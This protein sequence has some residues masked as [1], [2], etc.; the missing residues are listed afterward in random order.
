MLD[1]VGNRFQH[2]FR[3]DVVLKHLPQFKN[4]VQLLDTAM[5]ALAAIPVFQIAQV[6]AVTQR[7]FCCQRRQ[8]CNRA[9][10]EEMRLFVI[11]MDHAD[12]PILVG[13]GGGNRRT[14]VLWDGR[15]GCFTTEGGVV[16]NDH[17]FFGVAH[18]F[19]F[20]VGKPLCR[21][22]LTEA[23]VKLRL[24]G[25][26][27]LR[28]WREQ[29]NRVAVRVGG[30]DRLVPDHV[31]HGF[32]VER[33][34]QFVADAGDRVEF[35]QAAAQVLTRRFVKSNTIQRRRD[36]DGEGGEKLHVLFR[37][38]AIDTVHHAHLAERDVADGKRNQHRLLDVQAL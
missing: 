37:K 18:R 33:L 32:K 20:D 1:T 30:A 3:I 12:H 22:P 4:L 10:V 13:E 14:R 11:Q 16:F 8:E 31:Q 28:W 23:T 9:V 38:I 17:R 35:E 26:V 24:V 15:H 34:R 25:V 5:Q 27:P 2:R 36:L 29:R 19:F 6:V 21:T 7:G